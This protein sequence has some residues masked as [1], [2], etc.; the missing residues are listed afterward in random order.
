MTTAV[1]TII[2]DAL[3]ARVAGLRFDPNLPIAWPNK[4]FSPPADRKWLRVNDLPLPTQ[5]FALAVG[6]TNEYTGLIQI[7]VF[8]PLNEGIAKARAIAGVIAAAFQ[9]RSKLYRAGLTVKITQTSLGPILTEPLNIMLPVTVRY[10]AF[11]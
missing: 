5:P 9:P 1:E 6:G 3:F 11:S 2:A 4:E 7:D 10:R 8:Q